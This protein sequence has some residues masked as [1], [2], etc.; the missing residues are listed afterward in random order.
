MNMNYS[1][2]KTILHL[3]RKKSKKIGVSLTAQ[4]PE[5]MRCGYAPIPTSFSKHR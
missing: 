5:S 4:L 3:Y 1:S 2:A